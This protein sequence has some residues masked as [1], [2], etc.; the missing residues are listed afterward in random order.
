M[1]GMM[2]CLCRSMK[3]DVL[4]LKQ[5]HYDY[6][7]IFSLGRN[8]WNLTTGKRDSLLWAEATSRSRSLRR[9]GDRCLN[10]RSLLPRSLSI[11]NLL[12]KPS[13]ETAKTLAAGNRRVPENRREEANKYQEA[14]KEC[15]FKRKKDRSFPVVTECGRVESSCFGCKLLR[16]G[17]QKN[18]W[19]D[20]VWT[21][22]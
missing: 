9:H 15:D 3:K 10:R 22:W 14:E 21:R 2:L 20:G 13:W 12:Q 17:P 7:N 5:L 6:I 16:G 19:V 8:G 11:F 18:F 4:V 1:V